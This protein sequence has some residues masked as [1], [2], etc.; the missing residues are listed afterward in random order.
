MITVVLLLSLFFSL[1]KY[2]TWRIKRKEFI[3][4]KTN[5]DQ[6]EAEKICWKW[7]ANNYKEF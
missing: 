5:S 1:S 6:N 2:M 7:K 4:S 3:Q